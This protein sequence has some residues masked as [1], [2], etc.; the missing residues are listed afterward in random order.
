VVFSHSE[1]VKHLIKYGTHIFGFANRKQG[2]FSDP[3]GLRGTGNKA[4]IP[5]QRYNRPVM[6]PTAGI[7][8]SATDD[9]SKPFYSLVNELR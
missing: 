9:H 1:K 5:I 2:K 3:Y 4:E 6:K 7:S 8:N